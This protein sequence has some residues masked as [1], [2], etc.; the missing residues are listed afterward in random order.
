MD[1]YEKKYKKQ[2]ADM[3]KRLAGVDT[4]IAK[5]VRKELKEPDEK[6]RE[7]CELARRIFNEGI[8]LYQDGTLTFAEFVA[9]LNKTLLA[10]K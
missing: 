3:A 5:D 8:D 7:N 1:E 2:K 6:C 4:K 10:I 9:D